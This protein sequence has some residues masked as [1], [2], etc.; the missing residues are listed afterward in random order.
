MCPK[1]PGVNSAEPKRG[2]AP[3]PVQTSAPSGVMRVLPPS[4]GCSAAG[5]VTVVTVTFCTV[6]SVGMVAGAAML[7]Q[8]NLSFVFHLLFSY[9]VRIRLIFIKNYGIIYI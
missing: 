1:Y 2:S 3:A 6:P 9:V 4:Q 8:S 7:L 5:R